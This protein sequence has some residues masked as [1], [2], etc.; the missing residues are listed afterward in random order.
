MI[1]DYASLQS[2]IADYLGRSDLTAQIQTFINQAESRIYQ[3][4]RVAPMEQS[5][6][7]QVGQAVAAIAVVGPGAGYTSAPTITLSAPPTGGTQATA[8]ATV[9]NGVITAITITNAGAG[10]TSTPSVT[11]SGGGAATQ[12]TGTAVMSNAAAVPSDYIAMRELYLVDANGQAYQPVERTTPF[13]IH[14]NFNNTNSAG[15]PY[16]FAREGAQFIFAPS[17]GQ[18]STLAGIYWARLPSLST[19]NTTNWLTTSNPNLILTGAM[20]EAATYL[21]DQPG[22]QYWTSRFQQAQADAQ[23]TDD[24]ERMSGSPPLMRRG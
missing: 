1:T 3:N 8:T 9:S 12:A 13:Y 14:Q 18:A 22:V 23:S 2:T 15:Q 4:L 16:Y 24:L 11:F 19:T 10:Y 17:Q 5:I 6:T 21:D 20:L 7:L